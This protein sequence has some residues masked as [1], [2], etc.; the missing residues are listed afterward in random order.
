M[1]REKTS[2]E[3][4]AIGLKL[5]F[6]SLL[7]AHQVFDAAGDTLKQAQLIDANCNKIG[8]GESCCAT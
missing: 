4:Q 6:N 3:N 7:G 2:S 8:L 5:D 1:D